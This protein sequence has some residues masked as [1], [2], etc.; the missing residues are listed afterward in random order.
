MPKSESPK[1]QQWRITVRTVRREA[2][3]VMALRR[4]F[5]L[6]AKARC[7]ADG[8]DPDKEAERGE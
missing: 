7:E 5:L 6:S 2:P 3:D 4:A 1:R 8:P